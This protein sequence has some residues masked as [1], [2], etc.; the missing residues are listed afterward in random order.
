MS[1]AYWNQFSHREIMSMHG[2][3]LTDFHDEDFEEEELEPEE[4]CCCANCMDCLGMSW[5]DFA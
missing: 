5:R 2:V 1:N 4:D 3:E